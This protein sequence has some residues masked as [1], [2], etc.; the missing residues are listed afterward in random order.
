MDDKNKY[1][2]EVDETFESEDEDDDKRNHTI[3]I[4]NS[5]T[6]TSGTNE[7]HRLP[8]SGRVGLAAPPARPPVVA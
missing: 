3:D 1:E 5:E 4:M 2:K 6:T 8:P 7:A